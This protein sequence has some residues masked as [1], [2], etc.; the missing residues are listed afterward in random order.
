[1]SFAKEISTLVDSYNTW[2]DDDSKMKQGLM[3]DNLKPYT[4]MFEPIT[5]N[6]VKLKNRIVMGPMGNVNMADEMGKPGN[7][8]ISYFVERAKGGAGLIT[9][10]MIPV[11]VNDD[12][13]YGDVDAT[14]IFPRIDTHRST[15]SGWRTIAE[16]CHA[17]GAKFFI[18]LAPG[19]GRV[20]N[21]ECLTK[22][23]KMPISSSWNPNFYIPQIPCRPI[24]DFE[25]KKIIKKTGQAAI[26]AKEL[27]IDGVYL[28]GHSGYLIEQM[29][30]PAYNR[31]KLGRYSY[32]QNFGIDMIKEIRKRVG[33]HFPIY[34]RIDLSLILQA[35]YGELMKT[36]PV[37]K[38]F[39]KERTVEM[40][41]DYMKNL[42]KAGVDMFDVDL[43]GYDNWWFPHP[44]NTMPPGLYLE[45]AN[46]VKKHFADE[47]IT[48]NKG[49]NVPIVGVGKLGFPDVA[50]DA[51]RKNKC[52]L[53]MLARPLLADPFWPNKVYKGE[54]DRI[55]PCIGDHEG[56]LGQ[57][58]S[59]GHPHCAVNPRTAFEDVY[60][61]DL[62]LTENRKKIVVVGAGPAGVILALTLDKRGHDVTIIDSNDIAG[63]SLLGGSVPKIKYEIKNYVTYLNNEIKVNNI[64]TMFNTIAD[65]N[66]LKELKPDVL[67][68]CSG[69]TAL[70]PPVKGIN[71]KNVIPAMEYLNNPDKYSKFNNYTVI[72]GADVGCEV[73]HM[74]S[75]EYGKK[76]TIVEMG[77]HLMPKTCTS[78]RHSLIYYLNKKG[79]NLFNCTTL[80]EVKDGSI[81]VSRNMS[82]TV[83]SPIN[84][85][86]PLIPENI[87]NPFAKKVKQNYS[88]QELKSDLII[89]ATGAKPNDDLYYKLTKERISKEIFNI[90][91]SFTPGRVLEAVKAGYALGNTI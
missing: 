63:G 53:V 36:E 12:P 60:Q 70:V 7:K 48:T 55:I 76:V 30:D 59:G 15:Y 58:D 91:D 78:N 32:Y 35:T 75:Y 50:E 8:L 65:S 47:G 77:D 49:Q 6:S 80:K 29:T 40:T 68:T 38:K 1:M 46:L 44:P 41:L 3:S 45:V 54:V 69:T 9:T 39:A 5:I 18:Q 24:T 57:L 4:S 52:D 16:G 67:V 37:L 27:Q 83:P 61:N 21:P 23:F 82:K 86:T 64:K 17:H 28:H 51:L 31:R 22:K 74:L 11:S 90:G 43:G 26:D 2:F 10:G 88:D 13:S 34:Y 84:T 66:M 56:C 14:G 33:V 19:M 79:V 20:G 87:I 81:I 85:W 72:G 73:A 42:V 89:L 25:C 71:N 62:K